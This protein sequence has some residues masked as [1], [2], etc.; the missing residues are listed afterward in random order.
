MKFTAWDKLEKRFRNDVVISP[1][2]A[3]HIDR[4]SPDFNKMV[5]KW[6]RKRGDI[7]GG[8]YAEIDYTDWYG[9][10]NIEIKI[11]E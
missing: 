10:T 11:I 7:L 1:N 8:D 9:Q 2:G 6:Y 3:I 4:S 5:N